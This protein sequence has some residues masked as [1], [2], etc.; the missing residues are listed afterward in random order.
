LYVARIQVVHE[1]D[2]TSLWLL[3]LHCGALD[4]PYLLM[5]LFL[6]RFRK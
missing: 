2:E 6:L 5:R 1:L 3:A 4:V